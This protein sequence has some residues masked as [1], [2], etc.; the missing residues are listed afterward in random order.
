MATTNPQQWIEDVSNWS[1][2]Q[3][4]VYENAKHLIALYD[5]SGLAA[6]ITALE[7]DGDL[8]PG[9]GDMTKGDVLNWDNTA[10]AVVGLM[11]NGGMGHLNNLIKTISTYPPTV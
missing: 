6:E 11:E 7:N 3:I 2:D 5:G 8:A 1:A 9:M 10:A 4:A